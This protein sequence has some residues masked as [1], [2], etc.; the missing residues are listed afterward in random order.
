MNDTPKEAKYC[1]AMIT[2]CAEMLELADKTV[3]EFGFPSFTKLPA[4]IR[5]R[6]YDMYLNNDESAMAIIPFVKK[7][8]C[9]C[10]PHEPPPYTKYTRFDIRLALTSKQISNE[11]LTCLYSR[12][13]CVLCQ[14][15]LV[16]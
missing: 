15:P 9:Y 12:R 4:E 2:G 13:V 3:E 1:L 11:V 16:L 7:G 5:N 10:A 14:L 8:N 6:I